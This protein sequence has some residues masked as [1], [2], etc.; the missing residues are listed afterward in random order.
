MAAVDVFE[1]SV[2]RPARALFQPAPC[3]PGL[4]RCRCPTRG[5]VY[6]AGLTKRVTGRVDETGLRPG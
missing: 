3:L 6:E 1:R 4:M 2:W 5:L